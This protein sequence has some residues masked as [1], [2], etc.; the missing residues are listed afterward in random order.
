MNNK[1]APES[2]IEVYSGPLEVKQKTKYRDEGEGKIL[3]VLYPTPTIEFEIY[4]PT[5]NPPIWAGEASLKLVEF[6]ISVVSYVTRLTKEAGKTGQSV[7]ICGTIWQPI[8]IETGR[9]LKC[10]KFNLINF[11]LPWTCRLTIPMVSKSEGGSRTV[12]SLGCC[13][14]CCQTDHAAS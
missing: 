12:S 3:L 13:Q 11:H 1:Q 14:P 6:D 5:P 9:P 2:R 4:T 8:I 7:R 10:V